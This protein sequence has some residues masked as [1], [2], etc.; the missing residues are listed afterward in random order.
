MS[1]QPPYQERPRRHISR[2]CAAILPHSKTSWRRQLAGG[3]EL[4]DWWVGL[5]A[6]DAGGAARR[7]GIDTAMENPDGAVAAH[8]HG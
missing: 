6:T 2:D 4:Q 3:I 5:A 7:R 8:E 1:S